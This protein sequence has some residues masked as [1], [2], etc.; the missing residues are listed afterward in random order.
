MG[1]KWLLGHSTV[2]HSQQMGL[3]ALFWNVRRLGRA[4]KRRVVK[5]AVVHSKCNVVCF[6]ETKLEEIN[7]RI[8]SSSCGGRIDSWVYLGASG[9]AGVLLTTWNSKEVNG[10]PLH[11][12]R[13]FISTVHSFSSQSSVEWLLMNVY[14]PVDTTLRRSFLEEI[15]SIKDCWNRPWALVGDFNMVHYPEERKGSTSSHASSADFNL[16][17]EQ[18][19]LL[20]IR[21]AQK[22]FA[23]RIH[24]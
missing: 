13:F 10:H 5:N 18:M 8:I 6:Q 17:I 11:K 3:A 12:G 2:F 22:N 15:R 19:Q 4:S 1:A 23:W 9:S 14:S 20:E 7:S 16:F 24:P 21:I